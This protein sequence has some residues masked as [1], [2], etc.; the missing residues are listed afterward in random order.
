MHEQAHHKAICP[1]FWSSPMGNK[2]KSLGAESLLFSVYLMTAPNRPAGEAEYKLSLLE[3][4][5]DTGLKSMSLLLIFEEFN[6]V[7]FCDFCS[8]TETVTLL[9]AKTFVIDTPVDTPMIEQSL[10]IET[11]SQQALISTAATT[12]KTNNKR[13]AEYGFDAFWSAYPKKQDKHR[14]RK[15]W[16]THKCAAIA[17][18]IIENVQWRSINDQ[19]WLDGYIPMPS[20]YINNRRWEDEID[21][22]WDGFSSSSGQGKAESFNQANGGYQDSFSAFAARIE[23]KSRVINNG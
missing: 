19:Q 8:C 1:E 6:R 7:G 20:T 23:D 22:G 13:D 5:N 16:K 17:E 9:K 11:D 12:E 4:M 15:K 2:I 10:A 14:S 18:Q 3:A 21:T